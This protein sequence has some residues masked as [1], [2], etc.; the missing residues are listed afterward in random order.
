MEGDEQGGGAV[1][2]SDV[3][4]KLL[5]GDA[6]GRAEVGDTIAG[7]AASA[8]SELASSCGEWDDTRACEAL[9]VEAGERWDDL[10]ALLGDAQPS[11]RTSGCIA[12]AGLGQAAWGSYSPYLGAEYLRPRLIAAASRLPLADAV[13]ETR[14]AAIHALRSIDDAGDDRCE[15][16]NARALE[17]LG[18]PSPEVRAE[19]VQAVA[20]RC[21]ERTAIAA[22]APLLTDDN[23]VVEDAVIACLVRLDSPSVG[24]VLLRRARRDGERVG[25]TLVTQIGQM[26]VPG[27]RDVLL[28]IMEHAYDGYARAHAGRALVE[29]VDGDCLPALHRTFLRGDYASDYAAV[30]L[31]RLGPAAAHPDLVCWI[32][33]RGQNPPTTFDAH[34][35]RRDSR[36]VGWSAIAI[37]A[38][39]QRDAAPA[40]MRALEAE[41]ATKLEADTARDP[42]SIGLMHGHLADYELALAALGHAP[43]Y[44]WLANQLT[45]RKTGCLALGQ[46]GD[47]RALA[48]LARLLRAKPP[49][50]AQAAMFHERA[51][52]DAAL[53]IAAIDLQSVDE[54]VLAAAAQVWPQREIAFELRLVFVVRTIAARIAHQIASLRRRDLELVEVLDAGIA[55]LELALDGTIRS[56]RGRGSSSSAQDAWGFVVGDWLDEAKRDLRRVRSASQY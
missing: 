34:L 6:E 25:S 24:P 10:L 13:A 40:I 1:T 16:L 36:R 22:L 33:N 48:L 51:V 39:G 52:R 56:Y 17:L 27:S 49:R 18:D 37:A 55:R 38:I 35:Q 41:T 43:V 26:S 32:A 29:R 42:S 2:A 12:I 45:A 31:A 4:G 11:V 44:P 47:K 50:D 9:C 3:L 28:H 8:H 23:P 15:S 30:A 19:A 53:A 14:A 21:G 54:L 20:K 5:A 46:L 7:M